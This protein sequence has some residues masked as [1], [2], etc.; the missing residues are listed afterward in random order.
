MLGLMITTVGLIHP[1]TTDRHNLHSGRPWLL[2]LLLA[3][4]QREALAIAVAASLFTAGGPG[5]CCGC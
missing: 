5:Y 1:L 2:L 4:S 3:S